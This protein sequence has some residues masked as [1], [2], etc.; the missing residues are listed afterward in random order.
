[1]DYTAQFFSAQVI[2]VD[3]DGVLCGSAWPD[4]GEPNRRIIRALRERQ[5]A[6]V[7]LILWTCREGGLLSEAVGWSKAH[8]LLFDAVN[9]NLPE[10]IAQYGGDCRKIS[11]DLY[12]D[13]KALSVMNG[14]IMFPDMDGM[15]WSVAHGAW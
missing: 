1:M 10:R 14:V 2:A 3:F 7:K 6:G 13:D 12:L 5:K 15:T 9:E 8:G 4:V 11:A